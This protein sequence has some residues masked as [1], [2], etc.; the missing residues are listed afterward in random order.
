[1]YYDS[2]NLKQK[3]SLGMHCDCV[4]SPTDGS[5]TRKVNYQ[6]EN[7]PAGIYSIGDCR[8]LNWKK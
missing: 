6:V 2:A 5:F 1:M 4:Y 7:N 8:V 3:I